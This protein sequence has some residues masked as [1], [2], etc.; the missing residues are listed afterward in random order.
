LTVGIRQ[1][2]QHEQDMESPRNALA[3][4]IPPDSIT[5]GT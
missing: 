2:S 1:N 5:D 4:E 3:I